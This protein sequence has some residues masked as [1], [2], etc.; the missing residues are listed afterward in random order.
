MADTTTKCADVYSI[1][2]NPGEVVE[3]RSY[4]LSRNNKAWEG[5]AGGVGVVYGYFDNAEDFGRCAV[6]L[7][8]AGAE[9]VYFTLN[10]VTP[11]ALARA[12]NR[13]KAAGPRSACTQDTEIIKVRW[14]PVDLD[15]VRLTGISS[16]ISELTAALE[17]RTRIIEW[18]NRNYGFNQ[19]VAAC[20]GNGAHV[21][22]RL[23]P[24]DYRNTP[25]T[26]K[27]IRG[28]L[29]ALQA[30]FGNDVVDVDT[31]VF[32]PSRIWKLYG[33]TARKGDDTPDRPHRKS[34]IQKVS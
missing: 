19:W 6:A 4:G 32:N 3:I 5:W 22:F 30:E 10:P 20:S 34:Y 15:P 17:M 18:V 25:E 27:L 23:D 21:V 9:G 13:L 12:V 2:F 31:S 33:T 28:A 7:D 24:P 8:R 11:V 26:V 29:G 14:L 1:F 16:T